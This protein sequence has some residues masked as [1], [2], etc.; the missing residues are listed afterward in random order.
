[1]LPLVF[2]SMRFAFY[3][4]LS[5]VSCRLSVVCSLLSLACLLLLPGVRFGFISLSNRCQ[6][7]WAKC[8]AKLGDNV[9]CDCSCCCCS[10]SCCCSLLS[11]S[12]LLLHFLLPHILSL[13]K[14]SHACQSQQESR[15][16]LVVHSSSVALLNF[17]HVA[18]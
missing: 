4:L 9:L 5:V 18:A 12:L 6:Q 8:N 15:R 2:P 16:K 13:S 10:S 14:G 17:A 3:C 11:L 1:M 7:Q